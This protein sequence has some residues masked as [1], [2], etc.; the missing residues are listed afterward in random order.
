MLGF[1][2]PQAQ[3]P[4]RLRDI[5]RPYRVI[6]AVVDGD[7]GYGE[8]ISGSGNVDNR[9]VGTF[10]SNGGAFTLAKTTMRRRTYW[11]S[12]GG[13]APNGGTIK[14]TAV[15]SAPSGVDWTQGTSIRVW[16]GYVTAGTLNLRYEGMT[17]I[18][19]NVQNGLNVTNG[20]VVMGQ[21]DQ[22]DYKNRLWLPA[23]TWDGPDLEGSG[24]PPTGN[25]GREV[26]NFPGTPGDSYLGAAI[27]VQSGVGA[28]RWMNEQGTRTLKSTGS[29]SGTGRS[30]KSW[31]ATSPVVRTGVS[32]FGA[33]TMFSRGSVN[34]GCIDIF[35]ATPIPDNVLTRFFKAAF[36]GARW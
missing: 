18:M 28:P 26:M 19:E 35:C 7:N 30:A 31:P 36:N 27:R 9:V 6:F 25:Y 1:W 2:T 13:V 33:G 3:G 32:Y 14:W 29:S 4:V 22:T 15:S 11:T 10:E 23:M 12:S 20:Y 16:R 17:A 8:A 24:A 21:D 34:G 5:V